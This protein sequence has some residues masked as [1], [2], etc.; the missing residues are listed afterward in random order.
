MEFKE[1][2][3]KILK[4]IFPEGI[5]CIFCLEEIFDDMPYHTCEECFKK[6]PR[7]EKFCER[8]G[9]ALNTNDEAEVCNMCKGKE[10]FFIEARAPFEY[11]EDIAYAIQKL[12]FDNHQY[13]AKPLAYFLADEVYMFKYLPEIIIPVPITDKKR[14]TRGYN[15]CELLSSELSKITGISTNFDVVY[16]IKDTLEQA[17]LNYNQRQT[18]IQGSFAVKNPQFIKDKNVLILD[19]VYTTGATVREISKLLLHYG[20]KSVQVLTLAHTILN[21]DK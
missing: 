17:K 3:D 9:N 4:H 19:D 11:K 1:L 13:L 7:I 2:K 6:L 10:L 15:Q 8:C 12:K 14:K 16:K 20:A 21:L 18:N 5:K